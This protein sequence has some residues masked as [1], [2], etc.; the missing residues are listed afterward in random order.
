MAQAKNLIEYGR[1]P[2]V[3][4]GNLAKW[5]RKYDVGDFDQSIWSAANSVSHLLMRHDN[6]SIMQLEQAIFNGLRGKLTM[7]RKSI[8]MAGKDIMNWLEQYGEREEPLTTKNIAIILQM[9]RDIFDP[10]DTPMDARKLV[11]MM[12]NEDG[13]VKDL[14]DQAVS[15]TKIMEDALDAQR[16]AIIAAALRTAEEMAFRSVSYAN[17]VDAFESLHQAIKRS[18]MWNVL[19]AIERD[20]DD[21][22]GYRSMSSKIFAKIQRVVGGG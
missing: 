16:L 10:K 8:V 18:P 1:V 3:N 21:L 4:P 15:E 12:L 9:N 6:P 22:S 7:G 14:L 11:N 17:D 13:S 5:A 2:E 20:V 19:L